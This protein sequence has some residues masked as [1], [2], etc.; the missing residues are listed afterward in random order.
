MLR[1]LSIGL[2]LSTGMGVGSLHNAQ[3]REALPG[4]FTPL[5]FTLIAL[6]FLAFLGGLL[7]LF[8]AEKAGGF[9]RAHA[10]GAAVFA[11]VIEGLNLV[12]TLASEGSLHGWLFHEYL[13]VIVAPLILVV[14]LMKPQKA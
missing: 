10:L 2:I 5:G 12:T 3:M 4:F 8:Y 11:T 7:L 1:L 14:L 6:T 13:G 9:T